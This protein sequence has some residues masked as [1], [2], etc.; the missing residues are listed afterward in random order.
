[1]PFLEA[2]KLMDAPFYFTACGD[3]NEFKKAQKFVEQNG[4]SGKVKLCGRVPHKQ[5]LDKMLDQHL[6]VTVSYGFDTQGLTL[7]EAEAVGL[8]VFFC[9]PDMR[10]VVPESG[11]VMANDPSP[12]A[13]AKA[14]DVVASR[15]EMIKKMSEAMLNHRKE[16][17]QSTQIKKLLAVYHK[18]V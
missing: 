9:D 5:V 7:L 4:M 12:T 17:L 8:P 14:L 16:I 3:G 18:L 15:P 11:A 13:M 10:E 1:M 2:L 6:S